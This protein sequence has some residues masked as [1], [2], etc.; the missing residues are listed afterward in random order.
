MFRRCS[1]H[2]TMPRC[3]LCPVATALRRAAASHPLATLLVADL[4]GTLS[5]TLTTHAAKFAGA[6]TAASCATG[7]GFQHQR[8]FKGNGLF[9][10]RLPPVS[11]MA[12]KQP[13]DMESRGTSAIL[14]SRRTTAGVSPAPGAA[15][16]GAGMFQFHNF[17][18]ELDKPNKPPGTPDSGNSVAAGLPLHPARFVRQHSGLHRFPVGS[19]FCWIHPSMIAHSTVSCWQASRVWM[20]LLTETWPAFG[21]VEVLQRRTLKWP[22]RRLIGSG[23]GVRA[24]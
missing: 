16:T 13:V 23:L 8:A 17:R 14:H 11:T 22:M 12:P 18:R 10:V 6:P 19:F 5:C 2:L 20:V 21:P 9:S 3:S 15:Q 7:G 24:G 1:E 4:P